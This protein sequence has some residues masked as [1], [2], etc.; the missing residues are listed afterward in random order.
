MPLVTDEPIDIGV[1]D[2]CQVCN[3]CA[4][5]CPT[6]SITTKGKEVVNGIEKYKI[7]WETCYRLRPHVVEYWSSCLT[8]VAVCPYTKPD[9]WWRTVAIKAIK[10][11]PIPLRGLVTRPLKWID[12][13]FWGK[14]GRKRVKWMSYDSGSLKLPDGT[15]VGTDDD[16]G[17]YYPLKE[18]A[19]RFDLLK[20]KLKSKVDA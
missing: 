4:T 7:N 8:C 12:D 11:T 10:W 5:A 18:N 6:N 9:V 13:V 1:S 17:Y 20:A 19:R 16:T 14:L 15:Q 2:F 3:K